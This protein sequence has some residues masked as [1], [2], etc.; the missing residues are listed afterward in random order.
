MVDSNAL[1]FGAVHGKRLETLYRLVTI[2]LGGVLEAPGQ[3]ADE[4]ARMARLAGLPEAAWSRGVAR[5]RNAQGMSAIEQAV[6]AVQ[7]DI[8][9]SLAKMSEE[10]RAVMGTD[11]PDVAAA[12]R[13]LEEGDD[14]GALARLRKSADRGNTR[15]MTLIADIHSERKD[16]KAMATWIGKAARAGDAAACHR[17]GS[18][19]SAGLGVPRNA[20]A[21]VNWF[22][23]AIDR[24]YAASATPLAR[25]FLA[26]EEYA[27]ASRWAQKAAASGDREAM[28]LLGTMYKAGHGVKKDRAEAKRWFAEAAKRG[29]AAATYEL[30]AMSEGRKAFE[31]YVKAA[32]AG[33]GRACLEMGHF[34]RKGSLVSKNY[35]E[36]EL[37]YRRAEKGM[38]PAATY[39]L[40]VLHCEGGHGLRR[41]LDTALRWLHSVPK[42]SRYSGDANQAIGHIFFD[43]NDGKRDVALALRHFRVNRDRATAVLWAWACLKELA[44]DREASTLL[45]KNDYSPGL[46]P[47]DHPFRG[48]S[49]YTVYLLGWT[50]EQRRQLGYADWLG[51]ERDFLSQHKK[52]RVHLGEAHM[53]IGFKSLFDGDRKKAIEHFKKSVS[54]GAGHG[55]Q[56]H[57][58]AALTRL[59]TR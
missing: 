25:L 33:D 54:L 56:R 26:R 9:A 50:K 36:A 20:Q 12:V 41:D 28:S 43:R 8:T 53:W 38:L 15:A 51:T 27:Q 4:Y 40:G 2:Q 11:D 3:M 42:G 52:S 18:C 14:E 10:R 46:G 30:A 49:H 48:R 21:A 23:R 59:R 1:R 31:L 34:H 22:L 35:R 47:R 24:G 7:R 44:K 13:L 6:V 5:I 17:L 58:A 57:A 16:D 55:Y 37:W 29:H 45:I 32:R 39:W 19:Y